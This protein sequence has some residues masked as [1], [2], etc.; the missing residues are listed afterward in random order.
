MTFWAYILKCSD[1]SYYTGHTD[2][3]DRRL[4]EHQTGLLPGYTSNRLP[5]ELLWKEEFP[6]RYEALSAE[7]QIKKWSRAKKEALIR[8]DWS[9]ISTAG[10]KTFRR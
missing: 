2:N 5:I 9:A 8:S 3:I 7:L 10:R 1:G 4:V 6:S